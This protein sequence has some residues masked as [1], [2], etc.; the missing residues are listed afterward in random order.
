MYIFLKGIH[1]MKTTMNI[2]NELISKAMR[3][4]G[5][6]TKTGAV[7]IAL[8]EVIRKKKI[9]KI[10]DLAGTLEFVDD[11]EIDRVRHER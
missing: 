2:P 9:D 6:K 4:T 7:I 3:A 5:S 10:M 1:I 11:E 8:K